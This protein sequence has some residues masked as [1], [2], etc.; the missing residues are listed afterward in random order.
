MKLKAM[1]REETGKK[2]AKKIRR[3]GKITAEIYGH[4][5]KNIHLLVDK[6]DFAI[7]GKKRDV[8]TIDIKG[9]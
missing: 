6:K 3:D 5:E 7:F 8:I 1:I 2:Y 4:G 9:N